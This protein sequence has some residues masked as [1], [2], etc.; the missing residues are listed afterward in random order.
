MPKFRVTVQEVFV[1]TF[2]VE[3]SNEEG[4]F[5]TVDPDCGDGSYSAT[6][7]YDDWHRDITSVEPINK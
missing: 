6:V 1:K 2:E 4:A 3:A 5:V 7:E